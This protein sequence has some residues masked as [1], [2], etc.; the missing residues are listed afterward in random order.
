MHGIILS[1]MRYPYLRG[2]TLPAGKV[3][4]YTNFLPE[5]F[6]LPHSDDSAQYVKQV[7]AIPQ[8]PGIVLHTCKQCIPDP[9][10]FLW[11]GP[12]YETTKMYTRSVL[13]GRS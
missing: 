5:L 1:F 13:Q 3:I 2:L 10:P 12:G 11:E 9:L 4:T 6:V 7:M 8:Q